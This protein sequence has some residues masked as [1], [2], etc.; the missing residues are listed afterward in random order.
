LW[1]AALSAAWHRNA[2]RR[3]VKSPKVYVRD[4]GIAHALLGIRDVPVEAWNRD[5]TVRLGTG[6]LTAVDNQIDQTTGTATLKAV[7]DN[8]DEAL[9][10]NQ[11]VSAR[12]L[13]TGR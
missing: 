10:P 5:Q 11:L 6:R 1:G 9:F 3:L 8:K 4:G 7:F 13:I 12:V 2:G